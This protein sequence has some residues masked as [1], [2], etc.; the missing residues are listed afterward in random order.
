V[1]KGRVI[2]QAVSPATQLPANSTV[3]LV[4]SKGQAPPP[5]VTLCYRHHTLKVT[6]KVAKKLRKHGA[7]LGACKKTRR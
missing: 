5:K 7:R 6:K 2:S 4:V 3:D 1:R